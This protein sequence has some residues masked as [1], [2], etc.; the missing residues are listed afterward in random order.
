MVRLK[1]S[2]VAKLVAAHADPP[3]LAAALLAADPDQPPKPSPYD[4]D[5]SYI[6]ERV[7]SLIGTLSAS[8]LRVAQVILDQP[9]DVVN[10][11][12]AELGQHSGASGATVVRTCRR[13]GFA[14]LR[15]LRM[16]LACDLGWPP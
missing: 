11:S 9:H 4:P 3:P 16:T 14:G 7:R 1:P 6:L 10:W 12:A 13:L 2:Q 15:D 8:E 5:S